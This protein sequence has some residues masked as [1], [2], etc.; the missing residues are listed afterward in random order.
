M[1]KRNWKLKETYGGWS[2]FFSACGK[3]TMVLDEYEQLVRRW[4][5]LVIGT[6]YGFDVDCRH[7][8]HFWTGDRRCAH[9]LKLSLAV[10]G[11]SF[12][13]L[14]ASLFFALLLQVPFL[15]FVPHLFS[16]AAFMWL[17]QTSVFFALL[18]TF[19]ACIALFVK[20]RFLEVQMAKLECELIPFVSLMPPKYRNAFCV[21]AF[22]DMWETY[23]IGDMNQAIEVCDDH[24]ERNREVYSPLVVLFDIP[25]KAAGGS[26]VGFDASARDWSEPDASSPDLPADI[27]SHLSEGV[28]NADEALAEL[29]GLESV[30]QQIRKMKNRIDFTGGN[31]TFS[32]NHMIFLGPAG[33]GK[34]V[35]ARI[36][37]KILYDFGYIHANRMV[38]VDGEYLKSPYQGQT[39]AR[40]QAIVDYAMGGVLFIDEAYLLFDKSGNSSVG[41]EATGVLLKAMEDNRDD[42]VVIFAGYADEM[43][44]LLASNEGFAS[45]IRHKISFPTYTTDELLQIFTFFLSRVGDKQWKV[46]KGAADVLRLEF[47]RV[48]LRPG[49]GNAR[50]VRNAVDALIDIHADRYQSGAIDEAYKF[51]IT[52]ADAEKWVAGQHDKSAEEGRNLMAK[53]NLD[54]SIITVTELK[55]HTHKGSEKPEE[56]LKTFV[57][58]TH[59]KAEL[60]GLAAQAAFSDGHMT[61]PHLAFVGAA[62]TGKTS[63]AAI[64]TGFL[65]EHGLIAENRYIDVTGDFFRGAFVGHTGK[66]TQ[67]TLAYAAGGVLFIDE[68]YLLNSGSGDAFGAEALGTIVDAMEKNSDP[69]IIL[70]G[71]SR[72]MNELFEANT[73][74]KSRIGAIV[75]FKPYSLQ[76][77]CKIFRIMAYKDGFKCNPDIFNNI[78]RWVKPQMNDVTFG[79]ARVMRE[80]LKRVEKEHMLAFQ[81]GRYGEI[82]K[83]N[84]S[85]MLLTKTDV[86]AALL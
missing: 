19:V 69:V 45:R 86:D 3:A 43:E 53:L 50:D 77:L 20:R 22:R 11:A 81:K 52:K 64:V 28:D 7:D 23:G 26:E 16:G 80:A 2:D 83:H 78:A 13:L 85:R 37:T 30:K 49:F 21:D 54:P 56:D 14:C 70:A 55:Q 76:E 12:L 27:A 71:Y 73:G 62:G 5:K 39:G 35:C 72:E 18:F 79:N 58:L 46:T 31:K 68:A 29:I 17:F 36:V 47:D 40:T 24:I 63:F 75:D 4:S 48:R 44:R 15:S 42:L 6:T 41:A 8:A 61:A 57:G 33:S 10:A 32:A 1:A 59:A 9:M 74:L 25:Y 38:E 82:S 34:T 67:A 51:V 84:P 65:F 66:R 60:E